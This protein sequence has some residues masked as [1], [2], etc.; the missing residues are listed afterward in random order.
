ME[1]S[2]NGMDEEDKKWSIINSKKVN[3]KCGCGWTGNASF[4][5]TFCR[6]FEED[7]GT[8]I[9]YGKKGL[10]LKNKILSLKYS[11]TIYIRLN[12]FI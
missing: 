6:N 12:Y 9:K 7:L 10:W 4:L 5:W 2:N 3:F 11:E 1:A 8:L